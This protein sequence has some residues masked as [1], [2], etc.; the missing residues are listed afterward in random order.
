MGSDRVASLKGPAGRVLLAVSGG[1]AAYKVPELVRALVKEGHSVLRTNGD[2]KRSA[3]AVSVQRT[4]WPSFTRA[5]TNSGT[6]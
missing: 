6:L 5:R 2:T 4:L 3:A 1:I